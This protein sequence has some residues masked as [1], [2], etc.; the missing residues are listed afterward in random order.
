MKSKLKNCIVVFTKYPET[1]KVKTRLAKDIGGIEAS[2]VYSILA[3]KTI[4]SAKKTGHDVIIACYSGKDKDKTV[5]WLG[6]RYDYL[7]QKGRD[8]GMRMKN[9]FLAAF[10]KGYKKVV[11]IGCDVPELCVSIIN[12]AFKKLSINNIVIGPAF[13]G[14]YYLIGFN[15]KGFYKNVFSKVKWGTD[16]VLKQTLAKLKTSKTKPL[17]LKQ[18]NDIDTIKDLKN[19]KH[20]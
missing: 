18:L 11:I 6:A 16:K 10:N 2:E 15:K 4:C 5:K 7:L 17:L 1:G 3:K 13:D 12:E 9:A 14:G 19:W 20:K 8:I